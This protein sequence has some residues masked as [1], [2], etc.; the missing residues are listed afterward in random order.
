[1][2]KVELLLYFKASHPY[3]T[4]QPPKAKQ[5]KARQFEIRGI[6]LVGATASWEKG[7]RVGSVVSITSV[8]VKTPPQV[9]FIIQRCHPLTLH[10]GNRTSLSSQFLAARGP[11]GGSLDR[12]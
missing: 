4:Q 9:V 10:M 1:M 6:F 3:F 11:Q 12:R 2:S 5:L 7:K 8:K